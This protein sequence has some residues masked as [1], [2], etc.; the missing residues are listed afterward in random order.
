M[1]DLQHAAEV[2]GPR[3]AFERLADRAGVGFGQRRAWWIDLFH[4]RSPDRVDAEPAADLEVSLLVARVRGEIL[5]RS[6]LGR[7]DEDRHDQ[8]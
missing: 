2:T 3:R 8:P 7:V 5:S 4:G 1:H 6:E